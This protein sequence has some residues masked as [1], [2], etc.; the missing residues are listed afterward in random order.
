MSRLDK[1][2]KSREEKMNAWIEQGIY[3]YPQTTNRTHTTVDALK[4]DGL[5]V[6]LAGRI[7]SWRGHGKIQFADIHDGF[8][9]IQAAF[10]ADDLSSQDFENL[11]NFD[12]GDFIEVTGITFTTN[13]GER[14]VQV[15]AYRILS[16]SLLPLPDS[17]HGLKDVEERYRKRYVDLIMNQNVQDVFRMRSKIISVRWPSIF[18]S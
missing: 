12:V 10:K 7:R 18:R 3:P 11:S 8:G 6:S 4:D 15:K 9:K 13:A 14:T 2:L 16:K 1:M 5:E 17:W